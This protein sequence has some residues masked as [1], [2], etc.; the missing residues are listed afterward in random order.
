[1]PKNRALVSADRA[2]LL[3]PLIGS[4]WSGSDAATARGYYVGRMLALPAYRP[5]VISSL[6]HQRTG[7]TEPTRWRTMEESTRPSAAQASP[8]LLTKVALDA[9]EACRQRNEARAAVDACIANALRI[10]D[11]VVDH[12]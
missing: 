11:I 2:A 6:V 8:G 7:A 9:I 12:R 10:E 5:E 1:M 4:I 3:E